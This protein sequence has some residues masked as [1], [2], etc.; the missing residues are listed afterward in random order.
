MSY[1]VIKLSNGEDIVCQVH[2]NTNSSQTNKVKVSSPLK[3]ET[4]VRT[5]EKGLSLIHI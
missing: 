5:T 1:Q 4:V 3:M 2:E